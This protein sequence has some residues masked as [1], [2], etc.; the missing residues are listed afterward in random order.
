MMEDMHEWERRYR[1]FAEIM[2]KLD[3]GDLQTIAFIFNCYPHHISAEIDKNDYINAFWSKIRDH[4]H[5][6]ADSIA[7][8][9]ALSVLGSRIA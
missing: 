2:L 5:G 8:R 1:E 7:L 9:Q 4:K 6:H 3:D